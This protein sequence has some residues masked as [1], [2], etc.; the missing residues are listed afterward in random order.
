MQFCPWSYISSKA[1]HC[2][3]A[4]TCA[5][6][7]I[8]FIVGMVLAFLLV[9]GG[10][11]VGI[12]GLAILSSIFLLNIITQIKSLTS[13]KQHSSLLKHDYE[14]KIIHSSLT[15]QNN[16]PVL[17][18]A[19]AFDNISSKNATV[20]HGEILNKNEFPKIIDEVLSEGNQQILPQLPNEATQIE[21]SEHVVLPEGAWPWGEN[22]DFFGKQDQATLL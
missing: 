6:G 14:D 13:F 22:K 3:G 12:S 2:V 16:D 11:A 7:I 8:L 18:Q 10:M 5:V 15:N 4:I 9:S 21:K 19:S 17:S 1:Q 20:S